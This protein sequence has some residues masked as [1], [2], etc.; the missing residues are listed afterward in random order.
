MGRGKNASERME[1]TMYIFKIMCG[2]C[3]A[4]TYLCTWKY[5]HISTYVN[6][7]YS[8]CDSL[9]TDWILYVL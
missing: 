2:Y 7:L 1:I 5:M 6:R 9:H 4:R 8:S 3:A